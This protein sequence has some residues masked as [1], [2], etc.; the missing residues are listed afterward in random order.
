[1]FP[2]KF[3]SDLKKKKF[4]YLDNLEDLHKRNEEIK[5]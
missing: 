4:K 1:M 3:G 5:K 2:L